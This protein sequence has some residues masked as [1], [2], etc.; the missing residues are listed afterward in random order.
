MI[1]LIA[2]LTGISDIAALIAHLRRQ[3]RDDLLRRGPGAVRGAGRLPVAVLDGL[4]RGHRALA[5][6]R[7][8]PRGRRAAPPSRRPSST[9]SS[10]R[11][12]SSSTSSPSTCG[13]STDASA[14]GAPTSSA[15]RPTSSSAWSPS[16][17]WPG[18]SSPARWPAD[19][20]RRG[21]PRMVAADG[22]S[23]RRGAEPITLHEAADRLGVH[24]MTVYRYVR[25]GHPA[26]RQGRRLVAGRPGDVA[27]REPEADRTPAARPD[28]VSTG[29]E[30]RRRAP[31]AGRLRQRMLAGDVGGQLA[32]GRGGDGVRLR[33]RPTSTSRSWVRRSTASGRV[34][35]RRRRHRAG[36]PGRGVAAS[37]V[38]RLGPR[39][40]RRGRHRGTHPGGDA[41]RRAPR[42]WGR[43]AL[44]HPAR[45][46]LR[47]AEPRC[48]HAAEIAGRGDAAAPRPGRLVVSVVDGARLPAAARLIAAARRQGSGVT[49]RR[50]RFRRPG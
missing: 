30:P 42:S 49:H 20:P 9:R 3:R 31:W 38:G 11:S 47:G 32:G 24:Y 17:P 33:A 28:G 35:A 43:D 40:R 50:R 6:R 12:S 23:C 48:G 14:A 22:R 10:S 25:L 19:E 39:F 34:A 4:H 13:S 37:I 29:I 5:R 44:R 8:L 7:R 46:W 21:D 27:G 41:G 36:A 15:R 1:V 16:R 18:R 45:R 26:G 2:M